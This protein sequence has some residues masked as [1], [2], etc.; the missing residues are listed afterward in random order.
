VY[1]GVANKCFR[2]WR[3]TLVQ[4]TEPE[5]QPVV[6]RFHSINGDGIFI[7]DFI[8][9]KDFDAFPPGFLVP[10]RYFE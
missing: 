4:A 3:D 5:L 1:T 2:A 8:G 6:F 7:L 10:N 9:N